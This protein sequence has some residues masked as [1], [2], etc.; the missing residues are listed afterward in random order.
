MGSG[1]FITE[2]QWGIIFKSLDI[3]RNVFTH[4]PV[5]QDTMNED[6]RWSH[7]ESIVD[8]MEKI[9]QD[10]KLAHTLFNEPSMVKS[11]K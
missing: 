6:E 10:G 8:L 1:D 4:N 9:G 11:I 7:I 2:S 3:A 5:L